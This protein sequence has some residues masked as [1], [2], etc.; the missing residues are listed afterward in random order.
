MP[1]T[2]WCPAARAAI[3]D[4]GPNTAVPLILAALDELGI[5]RDAVDFLF[6]THVHLDHAGGAG[7]LMRALPQRH[8]GAASAR[9]A[10]HDRS[11]RSSSPARARCMATSCIRS[12][13]AKSCPSQRERIA[14]AQDGQRF[15]LAGRVFECVHTPG[16]ALHHQ[17]IVDHGA[18]SI[19]TG[20]T[21]GL[22]YREFDTARG[23]VDHADHHAHAIRSRPA[24]GIHRPAHAIPPAPD[25]SDALQRGRAIARGWPTTWSTPSTNS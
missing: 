8:R 12:C 10:A 15:E 25:L 19:F 13:T 20:D 4:T 5:A 9:R 17:A 24:Q 18:N 16:H 2:S 1:R 3:V 6:L 7:A 22:S 11:R 23:A 21:F 14:I